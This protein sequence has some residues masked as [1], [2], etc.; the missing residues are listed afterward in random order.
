MSN[1]ST[2]GAANMSKRKFKL[3]VAEDTGGREC[4]LITCSQST[5]GQLCDEYALQS[6]DGT[7]EIEQDA[8]RAPC[9]RLLYAVNPARATLPYQ[10]VTAHPAT[11]FFT[12]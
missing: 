8:T 12:L 9:D 2:K 10:R 7:F 3:I 1:Q 4:V 5:D 6:I 11:G